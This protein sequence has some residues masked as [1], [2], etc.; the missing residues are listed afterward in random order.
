MTPRISR[1]RI[2]VSLATAW[3]AAAVLAG[4]SSGSTTAAGAGT[5]ATSAAAP[6]TTAVPAA[7]ASAPAG[8]A[9]TPGASASAPASAASRGAAGGPGCSS[10]DLRIS[11]G[12]ASGAAGSDYQYIEF[13]D[14]SADSCTLQGFP[15]VSLLG[16]TPL[17]QI[18]AAATRAPND[19]PSLVTLTPGGMAS[20]LMRMS[21]AMDYPDA[22]CDPVATAMLQVY[23][24]NG[25]VAQQ[26]P[27]ASTGCGA[28]AVKLLQINAVQPGTGNPPGA[29]F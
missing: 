17:R 6:S 13:Q 14:V 7:S 8:A 20:A 18:G 12:S 10:A 4:C 9:S 23:P 22:T 19:N 5:P 24:P 15:G 1:G 28:A 21:S 11:L 27:F 2:A 3:I 26:V 16:G 25:T 29:D